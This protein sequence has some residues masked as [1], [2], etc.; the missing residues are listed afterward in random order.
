M[1]LEVPGDLRHPRATLEQE[2]AQRVAR[3]GRPSPRREVGHRGQSSE[4]LVARTTIRKGERE[5][6]VAHR[7]AE[8]GLRLAESHLRAEALPWPGV[9]GF[10]PDRRVFGRRDCATREFAQHPRGGRQN[11]VVRIGRDDQGRIVGAV[12]PED[13]VVLPVQVGRG[14]R[15]IADLEGR[16]IGQGLAERGSR[17]HGLGE[18]ADGG[19]RL[20][21]A[22]KKAEVFP[23]GAFDRATK[24]REIGVVG[25]ER[26]GEVVAG[27]QAGSVEHRVERDAEIVQKT[28]ERRERRCA[29]RRRSWGLH[30]MVLSPKGNRLLPAGDIRVGSVA[31]TWKLFGAGQVVRLKR[32]RAQRVGRTHPGGDT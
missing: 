5:G 6:H 26:L 15:G 4:G 16:E 27:R 30:S 2:R 31:A 12:A 25:N 22:Q 19:E 29:L 7:N 24:D 17:P 8:P 14:R 11:H 3:P 1:D 23:S 10:P 21:G 9:G 32:D 28:G 20:T 18:W 13:P